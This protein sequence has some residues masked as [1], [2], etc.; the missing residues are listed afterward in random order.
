MLTS[1]NIGA[2]STHSAA[3]ERPEGA[4][5]LAH[6]GRYTMGNRALELEVLDLFVQ[7]APLTIERLRQ[8][9]AEKPWREAAHTLKGSARAVGA[10]RLAD[11]AAGGERIA[12]WMEPE[13]AKSAVAAI[14]AA[15][16][17][18]HAF[19]RALHEGCAA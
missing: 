8:A 2:A 3:R 15:Y 9:K 14:E 16:A 11:A 12:G 4:V 13:A 19:I 6:L 7:Q 10:W 18:V 1:S 5:D 17:E